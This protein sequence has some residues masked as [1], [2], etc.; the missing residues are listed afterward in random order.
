MPAHA[1]W[2]MYGS[3]GATAPELVTMAKRKHAAVNVLATCT[4]LLLIFGI[5][6]HHPRQ[7]VPNG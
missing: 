1:W 6:K 2:A 3:T 5:G 4:F 7:Y